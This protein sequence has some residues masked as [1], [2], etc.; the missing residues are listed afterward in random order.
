MI[1]DIL[2]YYVCKKKN[3][4]LQFNVL[5]LTVDLSKREINDIKQI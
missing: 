3:A 2:Y 5:L 4:E 1:N